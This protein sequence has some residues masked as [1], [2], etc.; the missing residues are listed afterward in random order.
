M[1]KKIEQLRK[2]TNIDIEVDGNVGPH[3]LEEL[4]NAGANVFVGGSAAFFRKGKSIIQSVDE[5]RKIIK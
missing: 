1:L 2:K 5:I 4:K 3:N